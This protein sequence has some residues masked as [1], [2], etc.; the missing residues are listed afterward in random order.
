MT[1]IAYKVPG[2]H[3]DHCK[4]AVSSELEQVAGVESVEVDLETKVVTVH[5]T[6]LDDAA[7]RAA[8]DEA[9]YEAA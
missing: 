6:D 9:G 7:L 1:G 8:I 2:I 3:C 4:R 5:G